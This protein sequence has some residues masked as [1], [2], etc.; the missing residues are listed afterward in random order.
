MER[1]DEKSL[2]GL[3]DRVADGDED[4]FADLY[5]V[6][7][8]SIYA[9]GYRTLRDVGRAE[10]VVQDTMVKVWR[11]AGAYDAGKGRVSSWIFTVAHRTAI[12]AVRKGE[13]TPMPV[14]RAAEAADMADVE[15]REWRDWEIA[16]LL[17]ALPKDQRVAVEMCVIQ[18]FTQ[19][20]AADALGIPLSTI[21]TRVYAGLRRLRTR[22]EQLQ[23]AEAAT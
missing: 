2:R 17:S 16:A 21:K 7:G 9:L 5:D 19:A 22:L 18:G 12:D 10:E 6:F 11:S 23:L 1:D 8:R 20:D 3:M 4:A 14:E 13:R 15:Q